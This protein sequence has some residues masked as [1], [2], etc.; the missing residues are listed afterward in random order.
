MQTILVEVLV[1]PAQGTMEADYY[2]SPEHA[3]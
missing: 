1:S 3:H 2:Y